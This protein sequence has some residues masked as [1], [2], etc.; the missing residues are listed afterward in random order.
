VKNYFFRKR[1]NI[2]RG[3]VEMI[4]VIKLFMIELF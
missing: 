1:T 4:I 3:Y 2:A